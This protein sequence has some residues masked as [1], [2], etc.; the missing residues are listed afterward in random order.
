MKT[1][2]IYTTPESTVFTVKLEGLL[3]V[4][5]ET[6]STRDDYQKDGEYFWNY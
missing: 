3:C 1:K 2:L 6:Q 5:E 4:S